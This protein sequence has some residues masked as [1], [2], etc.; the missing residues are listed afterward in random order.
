MGELA[1]VVWVLI[2][3]VAI[4]GGLGY[5]AFEKWSDIEEKRQATQAASGSN[6]LHLRVRRMEEDLVMLRTELNDT[7]KDVDDRLLR[8]EILLREVE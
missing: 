5:A 2:P 3:I 8:I 7:V 6:E 4:I 1:E